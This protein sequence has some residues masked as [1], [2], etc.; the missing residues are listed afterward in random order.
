[1]VPSR[2]ITVTQNFSAIYRDWQKTRHPD[3]PA[4]G[5]PTQLNRRAVSKN[6]AKIRD[7]SAARPASNKMHHDKTD[8]LYLPGC[9]ATLH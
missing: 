2:Q 6:T 1:L 4:G 7:Y 8:F 3:P 5:T 9:T